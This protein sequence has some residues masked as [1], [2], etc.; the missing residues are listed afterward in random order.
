MKP[1]VILDSNLREAESINF[2]T[3]TLAALI[4]EPLREQDNRFP[5]S[6]RTPYNTKQVSR[7][8]SSAMGK[9]YSKN[10]IKNTVLGKWGYCPLNFKVL[11]YDLIVKC[12]CG[13]KK[14]KISML[15]WKHFSKAQCIIMVLKTDTASISLSNSTNR[16]Y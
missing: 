13:V 2:A 9:V 7:R 6:G 16:K 11:W 1:L 12:T 5:D 8:L 3:G 14:I 15:I 4:Q 10:C